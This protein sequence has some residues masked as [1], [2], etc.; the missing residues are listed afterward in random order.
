MA[1]KGVTALSSLAFALALL[2]LSAAPAAA[3]PGDWTMYGG[4]ASHGFSNAAAPPDRLGLVW[5]LAGNATLGSAVEVDGFV[6]VGDIDGT[7]PAAGPHLVVHKLVESNGSEETGVGGWTSRLPIPGAASL[8]P[9]RSLAVDGGRVFALVTANLTASDEYREALVALDAAT[10]AR[11]WT[12]ESAA[13]WTSAAPNA[14]RSAPVASGGVVVF[15]GQDGNGTVYAVNATGG[16]AWSYPTGAPVR[17]VPAIVGDVVYVASGTNLSY[18]DLQGLA[19]GDSG[20]PESG[21]WTGD[22][23][24]AVDAGA[25]LEAS[26]VIAGSTLFLEV[27][28]ETWALDADLGSVPLWTHATA[29]GSAGTPATLGASLFV[30]RSDG[31]VVGLDAATGEILWV[32]AG[33]PAPVGGEDMAAADGRLFLSARNGTAHDFLGLDASDGSVLWRHASASGAGAPVVAGAKVL[34][35]AGRAMFA[36]RGQ[37]DLAV[38]PSDVSFAGGT[39]S[40]GIVR[41]NVTVAVRNEGDEPAGNVRVR[42]Y[43][44]AAAPDNLIGDLTLATAR[45]IAPD[46][47]ATGTTPDRDWTVGRHELTIVVDRATTETDLSDNEVTALV[48]VQAGPSPPPTVLGYGPAVFALVAGL[49]VGVAV[50]IVPVRRLRALQRKEEP[51]PPAA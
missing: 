36:F 14:T 9:P 32:R 27:A 1:A 29:S 13:T 51:K 22:L 2:A 24:L 3:S 15:G 48:Y 8:A 16:L 49:L 40:G 37:P 28:A 50:L 39:V 44:G 11:L 18:L 41:G 4:S 19:D 7:A 47:R 6:Y 12:F 17:T 45:A 35:A 20:P 31:R 10:G 21:A 33:L 42:I 25:P 46:G 26:P 38:V 43:D 30:R 23:L 5:S 34:V